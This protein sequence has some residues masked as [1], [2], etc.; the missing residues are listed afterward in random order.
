MPQ[1]LWINPVY[2]YRCK[3]SSLVWPALDTSL[4]FLFMR[5][6][7]G[8]VQFLSTLSLVCFPFLH[9]QS[10][11]QTL[12]VN[13]PSMNRAALTPPPIHRTA[14]KRGLS[15]RKRGTRPLPKIMNVA[16]S[17][18]HP[19]VL[20]VRGESNGLIPFCKIALEQAGQIF[21]ITTWLRQHPYC[22]ALLLQSSLLSP[23]QR[24]FF[25][26]GLCSQRGLSASKRLLE[27]ICNFGHSSRG[28]SVGFAD[29][30][31]QLYRQQSLV[32][33]KRR[34]ELVILRAEE[35][36]TCISSCNM[37]MWI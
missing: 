37:G 16:L 5:S 17:T 28:Q 32:W 3:S 34:K 10:T 29:W 30:S 4:F 22:C 24:P 21:Q 19:K 31:P 23:A 2:A 6:S 15:R 12:T 26:P 8:F 13:C 1:S 27:W 14:R 25:L 36:N 20:S 35:R 7:G 18:A 9:L 11:I 33:R